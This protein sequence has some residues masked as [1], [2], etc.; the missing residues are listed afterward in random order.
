MNAAVALS[1]CQEDAASCDCSWHENLARAKAT[2]PEENSYED[3]FLALSQWMREP[4]K[5]RTFTGEANSI[6]IFIKLHESGQLQAHG[7]GRD[8][9]QALE[10]ALEQVG[11]L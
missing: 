6:G 10:D 3:I 7:R 4:G 5:S 11:A 1:E 9:D 8:A 2:A